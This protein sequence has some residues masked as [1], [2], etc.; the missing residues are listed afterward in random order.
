M[1]M[2]RKWCYLIVQS[3]LVLSLAGLLA[4]F[5]L[6]IYQEGTSRKAENVLE[7]VFR[8]EEVAEKLYGAMPLAFLLIG[9]SAAG[10]LLD[11]RDEGAEKPVKDAKVTRDLVCSR[12][13]QA[14]PAMKKERSRQRVALVLGWIGFFACLVPIGLYLSKAGHFQVEDLEAMIR[15]LAQG[16]LFWAGAAI[17]VL[18]LS[19]VRVRKSQNREISLAKERLAEE[20]KEGFTPPERD[21]KKEGSFFPLQLALLGLAIFFIVAGVINHSALDVFVKAANICTEC[22]G[23]G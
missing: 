7:A 23:L 6:T 21:A 5:T 14:S 10:L 18:W 2:N 13:V 4:F 12:V 15:G 3:V 22:I 8:P 20:K 1:V 16:V 19:L 11:V 17:V 9:M